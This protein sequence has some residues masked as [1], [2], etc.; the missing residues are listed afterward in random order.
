MKERFESKILKTDSCWLWQGMVNSKG[1]NYGRF[2]IGKRM[3]LAH[4]ASYEIF[5]GPIPVGKVVCHTCD[6]PSCV[7]PNH[8]WLGT[9]SQNIKDAVK[10]NR[11]IQGNVRGQY[12]GEKHP[13]AKLSNTQVIQ[14]KEMIADGWRNCDIAHCFDVNRATISH[15]RYGKRRA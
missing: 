5:I 6:N 14:I 10:K 15:I 13:N 9:Q 4:R 12:K 1:G 8:L 2:R 7:N 11:W 3:V